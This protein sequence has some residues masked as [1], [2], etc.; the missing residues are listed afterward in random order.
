MPVVTHNQL[1][2]YNY[3]GFVVYLY[4]EQHTKW[5]FY[6]FYYARFTPKSQPQWSPPFDLEGQAMEI[7]EFVI[8]ELLTDYT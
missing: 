8:D 4:W 5:W 3:R 2:N 7:A 1:K 6:G